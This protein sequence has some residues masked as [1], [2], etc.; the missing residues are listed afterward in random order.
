[1]AG[2]INSTNRVSGW[3]DYD[4]STPRARLTVW[5][6]GN[7]PSC[8]ILPTNTH[9]LLA[10]STMVTNAT[11]NTGAWWQRQFD[12]SVW[13][14][15]KGFLEVVWIVNTLPGPSRPT[16]RTVTKQK[17]KVRLKSR[18][19]I[20]PAQH[21]YNEDYGTRYYSPNC[22]LYC[23]RLPRVSRAVDAVGPVANKTSVSWW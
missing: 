5:S 13:S 3:A 8:Q 16:F 1:M 21:T 6:L 17:E 15:L 18:L 22:L 10:E 11:V 12:A 19:H 2:C 4:F 7:V 20:G 23:C 14:C 9:L